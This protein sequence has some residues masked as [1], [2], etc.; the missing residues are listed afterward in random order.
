M[1]SQSGTSN[2]YPRDQCTWW[3]DERYHELTGLYV[4]WAANAKDWAS[5]APSYGWVVGTRA[6]EPSIIC[7]Q[8]GVQLAGVPDGHVGI[9]ESVLSDGSVSAS[10]LNWGV[11]PAQRANVQNVTFH[12]GAG[13]S[14]IYASD[15]NTPSAPASNVLATLGQ[16]VLSEVGVPSA[17]ISVTSQQTQTLVGG[18]VLAASVAALAGLM[19]FLG[20]GL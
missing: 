9:V 2:Q 11:T 15:G 4:P 7:L 13:V 6:V 5:E 10:N 19:L 8:P 1:S 20:G 17:V 12:P 3:A 16:K 14:F 18:G